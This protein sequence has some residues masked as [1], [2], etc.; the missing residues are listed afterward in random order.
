MP[1]KTTKKTTK[2]TKKKSGKKSERLRWF[3]DEMEW[4]DGK[5]NVVPHPIY[6]KRPSSLEGKTFMKSYLNSVRKNESLNDF[7]K[8]NGK[9]SKE[10]VQKRAKQ[11][12][13]AFQDLTEAHGTR[14][15]FKLL[16]E[17]KLKKAQSE[18]FEV[19]GVL[20]AIGSRQKSDP[21]IQQ[22][23]PKKSED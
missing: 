10:E 13:K 1:K 4:R 16:R 6:S 9:F 3:N 12:R 20:V 15:T 8:M 21:R 18:G 2:K 5:G 22:L 11:F 23:L 17:K 19:A 7:M 14:D